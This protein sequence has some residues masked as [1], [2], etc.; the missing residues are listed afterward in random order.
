MRGVYGVGNILSFGWHTVVLVQ[1]NLARGFSQCLQRAPFLRQHVG[2]NSACTPRT[3]SGILSFGSGGT[4]TAKAMKLKA[5][6]HAIRVG[7]SRAFLGDVIRQAV[8]STFGKVFATSFAGVLIAVTV[9]IEFSPADKVL[10]DK[11]IGLSSHGDAMALGGWLQSGMKPGPKS[12][13]V[14]AG[15]IA[16]TASR[17]RSGT[18]T[19]GIQRRPQEKTSRRRTAQSSS[20][21]QKKVQLKKWQIRPDG[22]S[23]YVDRQNSHTD[24]GPGRF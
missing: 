6:T 18:R 13:M 3:I 11:R 14:M 8:D 21:I 1:I 15:R 22:D 9:V 5:G 23:A 16:R 7:N 17:C 4:S 2:G 10:E 19:R 24:L 12:G 20:R